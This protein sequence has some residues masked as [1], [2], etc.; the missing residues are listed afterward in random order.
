MLAEAALFP[1]VDCGD[2]AP[3]RAS[4]DG[5]SPS[6]QYLAGDGMGNVGLVSSSAGSSVCGTRYDPFGTSTSA[7]P[8]AACSAT[9]TSNDLAYRDGRKDATTGDY[10]MG[11][12]TYDPTKAQ[13]TTPDTY[14]AAG[15]PAKDLSVGTDPL[16]ANRYNYVNGDPVN[17]VDPDGH[18]PCQFEQTPCTGPRHQPASGPG[19]SNSTRTPASGAAY[20][21]CDTH[22]CQQNEADLGGSPGSRI[23]LLCVVRTSAN[24][25]CSQVWADT[26]ESEFSCRQ[27][28]TVQGGPSSPTGGACVRIGSV[29]G[30][31]DLTPESHAF[32]D[33]TYCLQ[34]VLAGGGACGG[35]PPEASAGEMLGALAT[36]LPWDDILGGAVDLTTALARALRGGNEA[37]DAAGGIGALRPLRAAESGGYRPPPSLRGMVDAEG[38]PLDAQEYIDWLVARLQADASAGVLVPAAR[39]IGQLPRSYIV[40]G[41][42]TITG[43]GVGAYYGFR[44]D[45]QPTIQERH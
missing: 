44:N 39:S 9:L 12:R 17:L 20:T 35:E 4:A 7:A 1:G 27:L 10:Q 45:D 38:K 16:T 42:L 14:R 22:L 29:Y 41:G 40:I 26:P 19:T 21:P 37:S 30:G 6:F 8:L 3:L 2:E 43:I 33:I 24:V 23:G 36:V 13:F 11:A 15:G 5:S 32:K 31:E 18:D 34:S 25:P 28:V